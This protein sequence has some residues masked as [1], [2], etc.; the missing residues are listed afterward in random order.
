MAM[1]AAAPV[2]A[3]REVTVAASPEVV[4]ATLTEVDRWPAWNPDVAWVRPDGP[5]AAGMTFRW[6]SGP[7][8][9]HSTIRELE[10]PRRLVLVGGTLGVA[11]RHDWRLEP[12]PAGGTIVRTEETWGGPLARLLR[13]RLQAR[14]ERRLDERLAHLRAEAERR[15][16]PSS[17]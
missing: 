1:T 6:K 14:L 17:G 12:G 8:S 2:A 4:W 13:R 3:V 7:G 11:A 9:I 16:A 5:V 15:A 10:P